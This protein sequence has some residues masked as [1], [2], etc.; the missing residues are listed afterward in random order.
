MNYTL[1]LFLQ[2]G[3]TIPIW[4]AVI[5][6]FGLAFVAFIT[7]YV[8]NYFNKPKTTAERRAIESKTRESDARAFEFQSQAFK[9]A[10]K[11]IDDLS[12]DNNKLKRENN[13]KQADIDILKMEKGKL[14]GQVELALKE[15][16][17]VLQ[18]VK[19]IEKRFE[20]QLKEAILKEK[21]ECDRKI[22]A[23]HT[24]FAE[25]GKT[26]DRRISSL[27]QSNI[28]DHNTQVIVSEKI[29][30]KIAIEKVS[31]HKSED[32]NGEDHQH[33]E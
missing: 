30:E 3:V 6:P 22:T 1:N 2:N 24:E 19:D 32:H 10:Q 5:T 7:A 33:N 20:Q 8:T 29:S 14:L 15:R 11:F 23:L 26:F 13:E 21:E 12:T 18:E 31:E 27:E 4:V 17:D 9:D 16:D 25:E 28:S